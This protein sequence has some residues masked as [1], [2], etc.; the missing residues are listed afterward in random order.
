MTC[1]LIFFAEEVIQTA[2]AL[3]V[4]L[5]MVPIEKSYHPAKWADMLPLYYWLSAKSMIMYIIKAGIYR[6]IMLS[7][8][9]LE[10]SRNL[11]LQ[12]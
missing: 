8:R 12:I 6:M 1:R 5:I 3:L 7:C 9:R 11:L 4:F 2:P 10:E